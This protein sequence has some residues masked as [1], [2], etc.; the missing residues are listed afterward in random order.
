MSLI[1]GDNTMKIAIFPNLN[2]DGVK[3]LT[4]KICKKLDELEMQY[5]VAS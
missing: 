2:N 5:T 3:E 1:S 4:E